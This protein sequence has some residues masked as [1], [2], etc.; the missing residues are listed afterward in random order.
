MTTH[1]LD[2][3]DA[4]WRD[5][6]EQLAPVAGEPAP[7]RVQRRVVVRRRRR[8][9]V[10]SAL[11]CIPFLIAASLPLTRT[12]TRAV[13]TA[14]P[15]SKPPLITAVL[16]DDGLHFTPSN[17]I[18]GTYRVQFLDDRAIPKPSARLVF[19]V[20]GAVRLLNAPTGTTTEMDLSCGSHFDKA[21]LLGNQFEPSIYGDLVV[22]DSKTCKT[23]IS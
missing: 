15:V 23:I 10:G 9:T 3:L 8:W 11:L 12:E 7:E 14:K 2:D 22:R 18:G 1:D 19:L 6:L 4:L 5:A 16:D 13:V 21:V 17:V 20:A